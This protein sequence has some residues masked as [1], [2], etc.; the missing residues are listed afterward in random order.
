MAV[1]VA[2]SV[3]VA[4]IIAIDSHTMNPNLVS[5]ARGGKRR[6]ELPAKAKHE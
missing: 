2:Y 3:R 5:R 4:P 6:F 1:D